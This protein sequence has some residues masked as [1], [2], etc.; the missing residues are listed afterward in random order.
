[1]EIKDRIY[2]NISINEPVIHDLIESSPMQRLKRISQDGAPHY[3]QPQRNITRFEHS[4]GV[5]YLSKR[6]NRPIEEQIAALLHDTPHTAFSHVI[7]FVVQD[8]NHEFHDKFT[9]EVILSSEIPQILAQHHVNLARVLNKENYALLENNLPDISV[10]RW[11]YF[12]RDGC[13]MGLLPQAT[14]NLFLDN[15]KM[16]NNQFFFTDTEVASQFAILFLNFSRLIWLSPTSHGAFFLVAEAI[17]RGLELQVISES[18]FFLDDQTVWD[19]LKAAKDDK[20]DHFL[21]RL[22]LGWEFHYSNADTAEFYGPN[23]PRYVDPL[24]EQNSELVRLSA[25]IP[26]LTEYFAEFK[27]RYQQ[28]GVVQ[29]TST[30]RV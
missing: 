29:D 12:M 30:R 14:I 3:I 8:P 17:K 26:G 6:F 9:K 5:W 21:N 19:K 2:G 1:M 15:I 16:R 20:I 7:D 13:A 27:T 25:I 22:Q 4:I 23:K 11:D 28:I 24:V 18:D 10:D